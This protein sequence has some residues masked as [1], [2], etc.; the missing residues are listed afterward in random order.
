MSVVPSIK[1]RRKARTKTY[2]H[3]ALVNRLM[4]LMAE[5]KESY[6]EASLASGL[7]HQAI[8]RIRGGKRPSLTACIQLGNHF[9]LDP[10]E[11]IEMAGWPRI[12]AFDIHTESA[13]N[14]PPEAVEVAV[15]VARIQ[16]PGERRQVSDAIL[17][18][19][20]KYFK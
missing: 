7:D 18:L 17:M 2:D 11:L 10:N 15:A 19:L 3:P 12:K 20:Q 8:N 5:R 1:E 16:N 9:E 4:E 13:E 6:R 14:L